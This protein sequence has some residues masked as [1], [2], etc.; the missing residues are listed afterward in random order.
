VPLKKQVWPLI[1]RNI[2][3]LIHFNPAELTESLEDQKLLAY[4]ESFLIKMLSFQKLF[5]SLVDQLASTNHEVIIE[6]LSFIKLVIV[7]SFEVMLSI[8]P[9]HATIAEQV[10]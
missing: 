7:M 3:N 8:S 5:S 4:K 1:Y 9:K 2:G 6:A 10:F